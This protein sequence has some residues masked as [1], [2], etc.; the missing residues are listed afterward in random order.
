MKVLCITQA[1]IV[2]PPAIF[3]LKKTNYNYNYNKRP[4]TGPYLSHI[5]CPK[6]LCIART[7]RGYMQFLLNLKKMLKLET[8][9]K[10]KQS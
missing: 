7:Q 4:I 5:Q 8:C 2:K 1:Y 10:R 9:F 6:K 3:F